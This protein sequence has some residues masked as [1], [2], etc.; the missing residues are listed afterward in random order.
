MNMH[1]VNNENTANPKV[2]VHVVFD[3]TQIETPI[4]MWSLVFVSLQEL[5]G[6]KETFLD[7]LGL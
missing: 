5:T 7:T 3:R 2:D 6:S 4:L 1:F